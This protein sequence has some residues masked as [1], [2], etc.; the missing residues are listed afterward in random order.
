MWVNFSAASSMVSPARLRAQ[1][2]SI[3]LTGISSPLAIRRS[4]GGKPGNG[5]VVDVVAAGNLAHRLAVVVPAANRLAFLMFGQ[6][7]FSSKFHAARFGPFPS[8]PGAA[9][10]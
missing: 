5:A 2:T 7:R 8:F 10:D 1:V 9:A 4:R 6:F 3:G